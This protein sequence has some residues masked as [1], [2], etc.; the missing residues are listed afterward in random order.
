MLTAVYTLN[1]VD[2]HLMLLLIQP[3]K[4]D[5]HLSDSQIGLVTGIA[6]AV[7][8]A[9]LGVPI[10]RWADRGNRVTI[11]SLAIGLWGMT[12]MASIAI[13]SFAQLLGAR[14]AA[15]IGEAG[16]KPPTYSL[17][18][19]YFPKSGDRS[20]AMAVWFTA[21]PA[22]VL[23]SFI[24]GGWLNERVGWRM[25]FLIMGIPGILLAIL[26]RLTIREPRLEQGVGTASPQIPLG[27]VAAMLWR[28]RSC[29]NLTIGLVSYYLLSFGMFKWFAAFLIRVHGFGTQ[30]LGLLLGLILSTGGILG[31]LAG[32]YAMGRWL[33][34]DE[35][36][37]MKLS[38][39]TMLICIPLVFA[40]LFLPRTGALVALFPLIVVVNIFAGPTYALIQRLVPDNMRA[41]T[42][43]LIMLLT[44]LIGM[45][46]GPLIVGILSDLLEPAYGRLSL[47]YAILPVSSF[48]FVAAFCFWRASRWIKGDL[49]AR[50]AAGSTVPS[51]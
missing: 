8:Y 48:A 2:R 31:S 22:A 24:I 40:A 4:E 19:D 49:R 23:I 36:A 20:K 34:D 33:A 16:C 43:A 27:I 26:F 14:I 3:I 21:S 47:R 10:A 5:L 15:A 12:V 28:T 7:F 35:P 38:A 25:T 6:F 51:E 1:L 30:E 50:G 45:G 42:M 44:N 46:L 13:G 37:Q 29:R 17:I 11:A 39:L 9:V 41:T 32:G 18:G